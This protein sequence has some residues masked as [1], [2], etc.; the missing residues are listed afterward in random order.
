MY[1][2][3]YMCIYM[4]I[5]IYVYI[6]IYICIY[7]YI[8]T[9]YTLGAPGFRKGWGGVGHVSVMFM[10]RWCYVDGW[11]GVGHVSVMF[12]LRWCYV[13]GW[14]GVGHVSVMFMLRWCY[15]DNTTEALA[16]VT[17]KQL[18]KHGLISVTNDSIEHRNLL[19]VHHINKKPS[20]HTVLTALKKIREL[21]MSACSPPAKFGIER[22]GHFEKEHGAACCSRVLTLKLQRAKTRVTINMCRFMLT[23]QRLQIPIKK[24]QP[25]ILHHE[26]Q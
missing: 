20:L 8:Y 18:R 5:Y 21:S 7:M 19:A 24:N 3:V 9:L 13:D 4:Y 2:Y 23:Q 16:S 6:Y 26:P 12:M 17:K 14:G 22:R 1:I 15:V 11:G 10:V 25:F